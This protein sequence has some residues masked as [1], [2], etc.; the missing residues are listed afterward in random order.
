[1][2]TPWM[3]QIYDIPYN[4]AAESLLPGLPGQTGRKGLC[5]PPSQ[6]QPPPPPNG[7]GST[8]QAI[9]RLECIN[10]FYKRQKDLHQ[11]TSWRSEKN[12]HTHTTTPLVTH[13]H[14][15]TFVHHLQQRLTPAGQIRI[16][17]R[18]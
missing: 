2:L 4:L 7:R 5:F 9:W 12:V 10:A 14:T 18:C 13:A 16:Y 11:F 15:K 6:T 1:M 3:S 8:G 17:S